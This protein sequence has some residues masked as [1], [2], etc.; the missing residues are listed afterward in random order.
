MTGVRKPKDEAEERRARIAIAQ[1]KGMS[2]PAFIEDILNEKPEEE[3]VDA[4]RNRIAFAH[5]QD[6]TID[7]VTL[8]KQMAEIQD[9]WA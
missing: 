3:F 7:I 6:E 9:Q 2:L 4:V 5:E 1:G 8:V